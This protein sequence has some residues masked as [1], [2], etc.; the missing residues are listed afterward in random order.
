[1]KHKVRVVLVPKQHDALEFCQIDH[2]C[3]ANQSGAGC[4]PLA[5]GEGGSRGVGSQSG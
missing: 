1:M 5:G 4:G 2:L 3:G